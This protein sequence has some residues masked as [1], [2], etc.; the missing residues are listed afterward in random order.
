MGSSIRIQRVLL[1]RGVSGFSFWTYYLCNLTM[2]KQQK[3]NGWTALLH[4][5]PTLISYFYV[6]VGRRMLLEVKLKLNEF[7][8]RRFYICISKCLILF[9][10][11]PSY[12][13]RI[14][15]AL[16][17]NVTKFPSNIDI[18]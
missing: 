16:Q 9:K 11:L 7:R 17:R 3:M 18:L 2:D 12:K 4:P 15:K 10:A 14:L 13:D 1:G 6:T 5:L 8:K